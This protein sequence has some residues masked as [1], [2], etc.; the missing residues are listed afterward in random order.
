MWRGII[1]ATEAAF[2]PHLD[3]GALQPMS[4]D[5]V[6]AGSGF[7][8]YYSARQLLLSPECLTGP[9]GFLMKAASPLSG[10]DRHQRAAVQMVGQGATDR[11]L[12]GART[13]A[14]KGCAG[15]G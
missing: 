8:A 11:F 14:R 10:G 4:K 15:R 3:S 5:W 9:R 2:R 6:S 13:P 1:Y 12:V 7:P